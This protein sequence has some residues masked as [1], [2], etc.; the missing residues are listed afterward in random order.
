MSEITIE[1]QFKI[2]GVLACPDDY[3]ILSLER[4]EDF[5]GVVATKPLFKS[6]DERVGFDIGIGILKGMMG[7][8]VGG[9]PIMF[10]GPGGPGGQQQQTTSHIL[11]LRVPLQDYHTLGSPTVNQ[12]ILL[13]VKASV[14]H[15][16]LPTRG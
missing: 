12:I 9:P 3:V 7:G 13:D 4:V 16:D 15:E 8:G 10:I 14:Q 11:N 1:K 5:A 6:E 2:I